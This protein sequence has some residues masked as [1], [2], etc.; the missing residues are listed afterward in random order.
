MPL[1]PTNQC[2]KHKIFQSDFIISSKRRYLNY[3]TV[4]LMG[5]KALKNTKKESRNFFRKN[6]H[7]FKS[8]I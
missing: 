3:L 5:Y 2:L 4:Y 6:Y 7:I 8:L 1:N